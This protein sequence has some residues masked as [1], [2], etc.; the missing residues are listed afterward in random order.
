MAGSAAAV[1]ERPP[2]LTVAPAKSLVIA[3]TAMQSRSQRP[4]ASR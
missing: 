3:S 1:E 4:T 2:N